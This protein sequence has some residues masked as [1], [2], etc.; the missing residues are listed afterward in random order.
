M[1]AS[2]DGN[3]RSPSMSKIATVQGYAKSRIYAIASI[4]KNVASWG[5]PA[6]TTE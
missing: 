3:S 2:F 5:K 1:P 6:P 4:L